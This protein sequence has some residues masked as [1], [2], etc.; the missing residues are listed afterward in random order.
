MMHAEGGQLI[1]LDGAA[2]GDGDNKKSGSTELPQPQEEAAAE[3]GGTAVKQRGE[4]RSRRPP[5]FIGSPAH[6]ASPS[7]Q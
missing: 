5:T 6:A 3:P 1:R 7:R 2:L 4:E